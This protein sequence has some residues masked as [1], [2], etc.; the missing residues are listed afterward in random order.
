MHEELLKELGGQPWAEGRELAVV[1]DPEGRVTLEG[2]LIVPHLE[3]V[4]RL[5]YLISDIA[6]LCHETEDP[7]LAWARLRAEMLPCPPEDD[8]FPFR[9][10]TDPLPPPSFDRLAAI[11]HEAL[12]LAGEDDD[13]DGGFIPLDEL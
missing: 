13:S 10:W 7:A 12:Q 8:Y 6:T 11:I 4:E 5:S 3:G 2:E 1:R 9:I